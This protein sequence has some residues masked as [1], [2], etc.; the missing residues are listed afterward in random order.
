[1]RAT[2]GRSATTGRGMIPGQHG[3]LCPKVPHKLH[4]FC[5]FRACTLFWMLSSSCASI[6]PLGAQLGIWGISLLGVPSLPRRAMGGAA[7]AGTSA[8]AAA[9]TI[10]PVSS[11]A[12]GRWGQQD[13]EGTVGTG[14]R[15]AGRHGPEWPSLIRV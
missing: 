2:S 12:A 5:C 10:V 15:T 1:M 11:A 9:G 6:E 7:A 3:F 4:L 14:S 8:A 13:G